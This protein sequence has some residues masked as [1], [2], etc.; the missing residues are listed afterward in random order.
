MFIALLL[1]LAACVTGCRSRGLAEG[2]AL[3]RA[4]PDTQGVSPIGIL[5]FLDAAEE[6]ALGL[7]SLMIV[8]DG[9]VVTEAWWE[10]YRP[11]DRHTLY[12]LSKSFTA[13]A[14]G[15]AIEEGYLGLDDR[16]VDFFD[17]ELPDEVGANLGKMT[18]HDLLSMSTG[19]DAD[20]LAGL[21]LGV[22]DGDEDWA[23]LALSQPVPHE[24]GT[25]FLYNNAAPYLLSAMVQQRTGQTLLE[26]LTPR[27]FEPL[28]IEGAD[29]EVSPQGIVTGRSG[30]RLKTEDIAKFGL[31]YLNKGK[32]G[33]RQLLPE[34]WVKEATSAQVSNGD[35]DSTEGWPDWSQ[36]YGYYFWRCR[37]GAYRGDGAFGQF[38]IVLPEEDA[39]IV[40][41]AENPEMQRTMDA[42]WE[43][44]LPALRGE[45]SGDLMATET[46]RARQQS[47]SLS[48]GQT[49]W[50]HDNV[51]PDVTGRVFEMEPN[52]LGIETVSYTFGGDGWAEFVMADARGEHRV[53]CGIG[54]WE[55][56]ET[57]LSPA[58]LFLA[59]TGTTLGETERVAGI[60]GWV[61][62]RVFHMRWQFVETGHHDMVY[63]RFEDDRVWIRFT[64]SLAG[65]G[66]HTDHRPDLVGTAR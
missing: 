66:E 4:I 57:T 10:P 19:H 8:K 41:T 58:P 65:M 51:G 62:D 38:C 42:V 40:M 26:F 36:G 29:W 46:L 20:A 48:M 50:D 64:R 6:R 1:V 23:A 3:P 34:W 27:L 52:E 32:W 28:G 37:H 2:A 61:S 60:G 18:V 15:L 43:F 47:L 24:P 22:L 63:T 7:H 45:S 5:R 14:V 33:G 13:T 30:L 25:H 54:E 9:N 53:A 56:T 35:P 55:R 21:G 49:R 17:D 16:V 12:S 59:T 44:L 39:V 11:E 31:L